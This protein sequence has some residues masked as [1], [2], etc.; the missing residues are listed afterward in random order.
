MILCYED[1]GEIVKKKNCRIVHFKFLSAN[2]YSD[3]L[4]KIQ[5]FEVELAK[6]NKSILIYKYFCFGRITYLSGTSQLEDQQRQTS[7]EAFTMVESFYLQ[8]TQWSL[9]V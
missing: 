5:S 1:L 2:S 7:K 4:S 9:P 8:S 6:A 3:F